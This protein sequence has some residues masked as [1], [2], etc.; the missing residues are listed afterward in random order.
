MRSVGMQGGGIRG[1]NFP[2]YVTAD[3]DEGPCIIE[4]ICMGLV[5][6]HLQADV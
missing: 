4:L 5:M 2:D 6:Q 3:I 1:C